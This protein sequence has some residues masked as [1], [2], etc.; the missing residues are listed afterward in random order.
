V[1]NKTR[2]EGIS[3]KL[4]GDPADFPNPDRKTRSEV[5]QGDLDATH[6]DR[7][8]VDFAVMDLELHQLELRYEGLRTRHPARERHLLASL[9]EVGQLVPIVVVAVPGVLGRYIIV[10]GH[11]RV[12][13]LRRLGRDIVRAT[14]WELGEV[15]A[16]MLERLL[17]AGDVDSP[18]EQGW[19]LREL[20]AR[21]GL[22][23][24]ELARRFDRSPS[25]VSTRLGLVRELPEEIQALVR[26]GAIGAH[27][28]MKYLVPFARANRDDCL[29][30]ATAIA[31]LALPSRRLGELY[32][33]YQGGEERTR[34]LVLS[35]PALV[36]RAREEARA[37]GKERRSGDVLLGDLE[38]LGSVARR[39][40]RRVREDAQT[41]SL[42]E[43]DDLSRCAVAS[44]AQLASLWRRLEKELLIDAQAT[45]PNDDPGA[46]PKGPGGARDRAGAEDLAQRG[47]G[48][49]GRQPG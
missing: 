8:G 13:A 47:E 23:A 37:Q 19:F 33:A 25:W 6:H 27:G 34:E 18:L 45:H 35:N 17:R 20:I 43:R 38:I 16:L 29:R 44:W 36:L 24:E 32:A 48:G 2:C 21:F 15:E 14:L 22:T 3:T 42:K 12:R 39:A 28:A 7:V 41:F 31:P 11:K 5:R 46:T 4:L 40:H 30:L 10:D 49:P 1:R 26:S 9:A